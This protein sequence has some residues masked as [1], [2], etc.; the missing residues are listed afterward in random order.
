MAQS[1]TNATVVLYGA[2]E[3]KK[4]LEKFTKSMRNRVLRPALNAAATPVVSRI[5]Q[6]VPRKSGRGTLADRTTGA[7][8]KS[9]GKR[10]WSGKGRKA[11]SIFAYVG[12]LS[13]TKYHVRFK[14]PSAKSSGVRMPTKY[15]HLVEFGNARMQPK[16][17]MRPGWM[18]TRAK[19][20]SIMAAKVRKGIERV[21]A[22]V[23]QKKA[24]GKGQKI[25]R[26]R[27]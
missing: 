24:L 25:I 18:Q 12:P 22:S 11:V 7:L 10:V 1:S 9:I 19:A 8:R 15:A 13:D 4:S 23:A 16:P 2:A 21:A 20:N 17:F 6:L 5:K 3:L 14:E 26:A 27:V